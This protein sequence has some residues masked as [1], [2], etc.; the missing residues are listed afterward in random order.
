MDTQTLIHFALIQM[1]GAAHS[2]LFLQKHF[3]VKVNHLNIIE[4][5]IHF[6]L[7]LELR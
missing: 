5:N 2:N 1:E 6:N 3:D 7:P 4:E